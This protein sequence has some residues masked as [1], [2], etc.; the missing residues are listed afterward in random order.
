MTSTGGSGLAVGSVQSELDSAQEDLRWSEKRYRKVFDQSTDGILVFDA[1]QHWILDL[2][3]SLAEMYGYTRDELLSKNISAIWPDQLSTIV[4]LD[5]AV[6][7]GNPVSDVSFKSKLKDGSTIQVKITA[8]L[9]D[10]CGSPSI[11]CVVRDETDRKRIEDTLRESE[12]RYRAVTQTAHDAIIVADKNGDIIS[13]NDSTCRMFGYTDMEL[14]GQSVGVLMP[15][16]YRGSHSAKLNEA[17]SGGA[18]KVVSRTLELTGLRSDGTEFPLELSIS[19]WATNEGVFTTGIIRDI[20]DRK[21]AEETL[22][23]SEKRFR[24]FFEHAPEYCYIVCP[25]GIIRDINRAALQILGYDREELVGTLIINLLAPESQYKAKKLL[26]K[27]PGAGDLLNEELTLA[28]KNG[29]TR[30]ILLSTGTVTDDQG[31]LQYS[32]FILK[33]ITDLK[34][35]QQHLARSAKLSAL[36]QLAAGIAH[37]VN[38][39]LNVILLAVES[40]LYESEGMGD[41]LHRALVVAEEAALR[42]GAIVTNILEFARERPRHREPCNLHDLIDKVLSITSADTTRAKVEI[43]REFIAVAPRLDLDAIEIQQVFMNMVINAIQAMPKGGSLTVR[44][45]SVDEGRKIGVEFVDTGVG[46]TEA[47]IDKVF[48]PFFTTKPEGVGTGLGL[49]ISYGLVEAHGGTIK[50]Q[51]TVGKGTTFTILFPTDFQ[52]SKVHSEDHTKIEISQKS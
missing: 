11:L 3:N 35:A 50:V 37:E 7:V 2:N 17:T 10:W 5:Q 1:P 30:Q 28:T 19:T 39:P 33:D 41:N 45:A 47:Q 36:G 4:A 44:T 21:Q 46:I 31:N 26:V 51:S 40:A 18:N 27:W 14:L 6:M 23:Q 20:A 29:A 24:S 49:S 8:S 22:R 13:W 12:Q 32:I 16:R 48:D 42:A 38:N 52:E 34:Q 9:I 15:E 25:Q 43:K